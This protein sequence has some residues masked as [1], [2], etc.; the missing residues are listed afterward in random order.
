MNEL[1]S[2]QGHDKSS[3]KDETDKLGPFTVK[4]L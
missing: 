1:N 2:E 4:T 3:K